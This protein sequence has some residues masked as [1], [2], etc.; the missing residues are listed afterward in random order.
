MTTQGEKGKIK[1]KRNNKREIRAQNE[2]EVEKET[3]PRNPCIKEDD[4]RPEQRDGA[5]KRD[6]TR[7][8]K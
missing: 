4:G 3:G 7:E 2:K 6:D 1:E 5:E 8:K